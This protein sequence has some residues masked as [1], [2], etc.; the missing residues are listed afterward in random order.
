MPDC[1]FG[2]LC[3]VL[4]LCRVLV[5]WLMVAIE[6]GAG[7][8]LT[9]M[10]CTCGDAGACPKQWWLHHAGGDLGEATDAVLTVT[11]C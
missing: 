5:N 9:T 11:M 7:A 8:L 2:V 1:S 10:V 4:R 3:R 6:L